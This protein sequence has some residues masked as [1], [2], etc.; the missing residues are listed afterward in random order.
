MDLNLIYQRF[1]TQ[2]DC[3]RHLEQTM[4]GD[5][6]VCPYCQSGTQTA[7]PKESRYHC[8]GCNRSYSVTVNTIFHKSKIDL[9]K[10]FYAFLLIVHTDED[11]SARKLGVSLGITKDSAWYM[12]KRI[13]K[14]IEEGF[15]I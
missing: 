14:A 4:W 12:L 9:Q 6:P 1:P 11:V 5:T 13:K 3:I 8:N 7:V 2:A 15:V 10:W